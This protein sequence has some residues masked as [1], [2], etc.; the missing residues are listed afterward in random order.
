MGLNL[1]EGLEGWAPKSDLRY[2]DFGTF[3][4]TFHFVA[5]IVLAFLTAPDPRA[6]LTHPA[7]AGTLTILF[8][9]LL[10]VGYVDYRR[11]VDGEQTSFV[12]NFRVDDPTDVYRSIGKR[13]PR[14][15]YPLNRFNEEHL[16]VHGPDDETFRKVTL[17]LR[18]L[19][20][21]KLRVELLV[22]VERHLVEARVVTSDRDS[23]ATRDLV[24]ALNEYLGKH[25]LDWLSVD[26]DEDA[27][28]LMG[29]G[30]KERNDPDWASSVT[31]DGKE[32]A[33]LVILVMLGVFWLP[34]VWT[35]YHPV[36]GWIMDA[37]LFGVLFHPLFVLIFMVAIIEYSRNSQTDVET[38]HSRTFHA[39]PW[40]VTAAI[41]EGLE[42]ARWSYKARRR[43][44]PTAHVRS[45]CF[46]VEERALVIDVVW[47]DQDTDPN[48]TTV[49]IRTPRE[50]GDVQSAL[51]LVRHS[52]F[53]RHKEL[54]L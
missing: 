21:V 30:M 4:L 5:V 29:M 23:M 53:G 13:L 7:I 9:V 45:E 40:Y 38:E 32:N 36:S 35:M 6:F 3:W 37:A 12:R 39:S 46:E 11:H 20:G 42:S 22:K 43:V 50:V 44:D 19:G 27:L 34:L 49:R 48:W 28:L 8:F 1:G 26:V 10:L 24:S 31:R 25:R 33:M 16:Q 15:F 51:D 52:V 17:A 18:E 54:G 47:A 2:L 14:K 41:Q